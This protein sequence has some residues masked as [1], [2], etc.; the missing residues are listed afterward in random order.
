MTHTTPCHDAKI[1]Q[2]WRECGLPEHFLGN[3]GTNHKLVSFAARIRDGVLDE[4]AGYAEMIASRD[5]TRPRLKSSLIQFAQL[6]RNI[7]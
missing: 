4:A 3:G 5:G 1:M 7:E 6:V 2:L